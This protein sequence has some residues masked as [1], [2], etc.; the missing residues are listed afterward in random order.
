MIEDF[1]YLPSSYS[2]RYVSH[3]SST[4]RLDQWH[5]MRSKASLSHH[6]ATAK[7][8]WEPHVQSHSHTPQGLRDSHAKLIAP[9]MSSYLRARITHS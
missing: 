8:A 7:A 6:L 5:A 9:V 4:Q 3:C 1:L 2:T